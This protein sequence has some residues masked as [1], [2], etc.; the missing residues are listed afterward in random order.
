MSMHHDPT[1]FVVDDDPAIR[2]SLNVMLSLEGYASRGYFSAQAFLDSVDKNETGC[3]VTDVHMP[4]INGLDLMTAMRERGLSIPVIVMTGKADVRLAVDA[5]K[6][7]AVDF[8]EKP[9]DSEMLIASINKALA[10]IQTN[11]DARSIEKRLTT[12]TGR[13]KEVLAGLFKGQQNKVIAYELGISVRTVEVHRTN[14]MTKMQATSLSDLI[15]MAVVA[16]RGAGP[17]PLKP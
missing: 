17:T 1:I 5:M 16:E 7:G 3:V 2:E 4:E 14:L 10:R 11:S 9:F 6:H 13:E 15:R 12:L 8:F